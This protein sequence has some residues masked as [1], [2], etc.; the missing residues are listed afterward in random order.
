MIRA[1]ERLTFA[2]ARLEHAILKHRR[3]RRRT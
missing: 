1:G 3:N 2:A